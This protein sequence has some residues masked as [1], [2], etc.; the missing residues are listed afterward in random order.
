MMAPQTQPATSTQSVETQSTSATTQA[1]L[2]Q[3]V[4][5]VSSMPVMPVLM[6]PTTTAP[7]IAP[8][9]LSEQKV[10]DFLYGISEFEAASNSDS[11]SA[12]LP[13]SDI[14]TS[15]AAYYQSKKKPGIVELMSKKKNK[16][17]VVKPLNIVGLNSNEEDE[18]Q[19]DISDSWKP[20]SP[21]I[22]SSST[23]AEDVPMDDYI[24]TLKETLKGLTQ[25]NSLALT[26]NEKAMQD[27][28]ESDESDERFAD[29]GFDPS[30]L[31]D[32]DSQS[33][34]NESNSGES[35]EEEEDDLPPQNPLTKQWGYGSGPPSPSAVQQKKKKKPVKE[36]SEES[37]SEESS[38]EAYDEFVDDEQ[39]DDF[40]END[41]KGKKKKKK[42]KK[43][44]KKKKKKK[45]K[46]KKKKRPDFRPPIP[47]PHPYKKPVPSFHHGPYDDE[48]KDVYIPSVYDG[49]PYLEMSNGVLHPDDI[50]QIHHQVAMELQAEDNA[51]VFADQNSPED[52][53]EYESEFDDEL[54]D[55]GPI[56][57]E[58]EDLA[59]P[60]RKKTPFSPSKPQTDPYEMSSQEKHQ[61]NILSQILL[62]TAPAGL[63]L[64]PVKPVNDENDSMMPPAPPVGDVFSDVNKPFNKTD[65]VNIKDFSEFSDAHPPFKKQPKNPDSKPVP[66]RKEKPIHSSS[67]EEYDYDDVD[68]FESDESNE[69]ISAIHPMPPY[70]YPP[71]TT[72]APGIFKNDFLNGIM[73]FMGVKPVDNSDPSNNA[74]P[75]FASYPQQQPM[76]YPP[77]QKVPVYRKD[78]FKGASVES[79]EES[80]HNANKKP[81]HLNQHIPP[82]YAH[83]NPPHNP[84]PSMDT[85]GFL[86]QIKNYFNS[87]IR[88]EEG[89]NIKKMQNSPTPPS[90]YYRSPLV[91]NPPPPPSPPL[92]SLPYI[93]DKAPL[94]HMGLKTRFKETVERDQ[95]QESK[96]NEEPEPIVVTTPKTLAPKIP[97]YSIKSRNKGTTV[98]IPS[99]FALTTE[100]ISPILNKK[101]TGKRK[102][103]KYRS[104][105]IT[106]RRRHRPTT[107]AS[108]ESSEEE[109]YYKD[110]GSHNFRPY[111]PIPP[112]SSEETFNP[113]P[114]SDFTHT[115]HEVIRSGAGPPEFRI[116]RPSVTKG[117]GLS[118]YFSSPFV[119]GNPLSKKKKKSLD[120]KEE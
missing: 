5:P 35:G 107:P 113:R 20:N 33:E 109:E 62:P 29:L 1:P 89:E 6:M 110:L 86:S 71:A 116:R 36:S 12:E 97:K 83:N 16:N 77:P 115:G 22:T 112:P 47:L 91:N 42:E 32:Q 66:K 15:L 119:R 118:K 111:S 85:S 95:F 57:D 41:K 8:S 117:Y 28:E 58:A 3:M 103:I 2:V 51:E 114:Y 53:E 64:K 63:E 65:I 59:L 4:K 96:E 68:S 72:Q 50:A 7:P 31:D 87:F 84:A 108:V 99:E 100:R 104:P 98:S 88:D 45:K 39:R 24:K 40:P 81:H 93:P 55:I 10:L 25:L 61:V 79:H 94:A 102:K 82:Y 49:S 14:M 90:G 27:S 105:G 21:S 69:D 30:I 73:N 75:S 26:L 44:D 106:T 9:S 34:S 46:E 92:G 18:A 76:Y 60:N 48:I 54:E 11:T 38:E 17:K 101:P 19:A 74:P 120:L 37:V 56:D 23:S 43:K 80:D 67:S 70:P 52:E 13:S 78:G